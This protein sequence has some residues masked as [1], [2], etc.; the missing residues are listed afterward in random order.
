VFEAQMCDNPVAYVVSLNPWRR[1][2]SESQRAMVSA[3][4]ANLTRGGPEK[5]A[6]LLHNEPAPPQITQRQAADMLA[7]SE[8]T[9]RA[10]KEV[11][12][13]VVTDLQHAVEDGRV[14]VSAANYCPLHPRLGRPA[15]VRGVVPEEP[16]RS[17]SPGQLS[18]R[19]RRF[20]MLTSVSC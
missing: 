8:R 20:A 19:S 10:A 3:R 2:L 1:H 14:K 18:P 11:R 13:H 9:V 15:R 5:A 17:Q 4:L 16:A 7:V 12:D 6:N